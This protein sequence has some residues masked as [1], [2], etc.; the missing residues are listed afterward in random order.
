MTRPDGAL[1][2]WKT[3][4]PLKP[5]EG[6]SMIVWTHWEYRVWSLKVG[7]EYRYIDQMLVD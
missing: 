1:L 6:V 5:Q 3:R 4:A 2:Q 7:R